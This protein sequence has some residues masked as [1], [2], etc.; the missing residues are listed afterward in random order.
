M[1]YRA[2]GLWNE[3]ILKTR[4]GASIK[5]RMIQKRVEALLE[6]K[7]VVLLNHSAELKRHMYKEFLST[8]K[9]QPPLEQ[10]NENKL[11]I[12]YLIDCASD[13]FRKKNSELRVGP[14]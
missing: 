9:G 12:D 6:L 7:G 10:G 13:A 14:L 5:N 8:T 11:F 4:M 2:P 3:R 1:P